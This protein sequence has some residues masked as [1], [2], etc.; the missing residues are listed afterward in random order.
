LTGPR[1]LEESLCIASEEQWGDPLG[2]RPENKEKVL[3][4]QEG[5]DAPIVRGRYH[6]YNLPG[7]HWDVR[8]KT[9]RLFKFED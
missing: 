8:Q 1:V 9:E 3:F 4:V 5:D 6:S 2:L 7:T